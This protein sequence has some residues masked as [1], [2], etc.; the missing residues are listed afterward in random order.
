LGSRCQHLSPVCSHGEPWAWLGM[1]PALNRC[2]FGRSLSR[3]M[4]PVAGG[5]VE[6]MST[7]Q[8]AAEEGVAN[9]ASA[10]CSSLQLLCFLG[11][12]RNEGPPFPARL[13]DR[14]T[15]F[16]LQLL[17][18]RGHGV[19]V[20]DPLLED[21]PMLRKP[22]FAYKAGSAPSE[23]EQLAQKISAADGYVMISPEYNHTASP[24]L[25]NMLNHFG[26]SSFSYKPSAICTYSAGQ[27]GGAR[28]A[29]S[30]RPV[31]SELGC[32]PVSAMIHVPAAH[33]VFD[34]AGEPLTERAQWESYFMRTFSQL[35]W[36]ALAARR[37]REIS[38]P[39]VSSP[40]LISRPAQRNSP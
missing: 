22:Y 15:K 9:Q 13:G 35:E 26:S 27:W 23:L 17:G 31:L 29:V 33:E 14:V 40:P 38:D 25:L 7:R 8:H 1:H 32:L 5:R 36:W 28:A 10:P 30:M 2:G 20:I 6:C 4:W 24:A 39:F 12:M 16:C 21:L 3:L 37:H 11:S 19:E 34:E 18:A